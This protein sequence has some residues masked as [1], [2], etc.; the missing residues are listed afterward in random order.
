[1][2]TRRTGVHHEGNE[3]ICKTRPLRPPQ[4][5]GFFGRRS[6]HSWRFSRTNTARYIIPQF[7]SIFYYFDRAGSFHGADVLQPAGDL[8]RDR[9]V[10]DRK[11]GVIPN[12]SRRSAFAPSRQDLRRWTATTRTSSPSGVD[13]HPRRKL[14]DVEDSLSAWML[15]RY[16]SP[17]RE[18]SDPANGDLGGIFEVTDAHSARGVS[19]SSS[20]NYLIGLVEIL[21][22]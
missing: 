16:P 18:R 7:L 20:V 17:A 1:M 14:N 5:F 19:L 3:E 13:C 22:R 6:N 15:R 8:V 21:N 9:L 12:R 10:G 2:A 11:P 4:P